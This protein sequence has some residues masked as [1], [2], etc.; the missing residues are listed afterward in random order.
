MDEGKKKKK[1]KNSVLRL[2]ALPSG[3]SLEAAGASSPR[4]ATVTED[5]GMP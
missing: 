4:A 2:S 3:V 5:F 1:K